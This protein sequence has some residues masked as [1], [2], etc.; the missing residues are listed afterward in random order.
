MEFSSAWLSTD[1][2]CLAERQAASSVDILKDSILR[3]TRE[4]LEK[5]FKFPFHKYQPATPAPMRKEHP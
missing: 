2:R 4:R 1:M 3:A 5:F